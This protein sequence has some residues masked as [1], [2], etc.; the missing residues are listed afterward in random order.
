MLD[1]LS[2]PGNKTAFRTGGRS[3]EL[4]TVEMDIIARPPIVQKTH[5]GWGTADVLTL[6]LKML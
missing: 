4:F 2:K 5:N 1:A 6:E 3:G